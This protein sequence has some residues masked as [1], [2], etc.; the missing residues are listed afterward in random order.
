VDGASA[1]VRGAW[2][3]TEYLAVAEARYACAAG[4]ASFTASVRQKHYARRLNFLLAMDLIRP[5]R[6][7][8]GARMARTFLIMRNGTELDGRQSE[9]LPAARRGCDGR[10]TNI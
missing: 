3:T 6:I 7:T 2:R 5:R 9:V 4:V 8:D 1:V 10:G